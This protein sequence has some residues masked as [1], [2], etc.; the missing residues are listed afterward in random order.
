MPD[1]API[2]DPFAA[3]TDVLLASTL[4][5]DV[6]VVRGTAAPVTV[7][8]VVE[9]GVEQIGDYGRV[10]GRATRI[11][12]AKHAWDPQRGDLVTIGGTVRAIESI[13]TD[14]GYVAQAVLHG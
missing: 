12:F 6:I 13:D 10:I 8:A 14:D 9:D 1:V 11:S 3:M 7:R 5:R 4:A 2:A